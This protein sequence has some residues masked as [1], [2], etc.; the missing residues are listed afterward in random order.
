M[1]ITYP[2]MLV[3]NG[4]QHN[5]LCY[6]V[7][8]KEFNLSDMIVVDKHFSAIVIQNNVVIDTL[9]SDKQ[10]EFKI[11]SLKKL[12]AG[13]FAKTTQLTIIFIRNNINNMKVTQTPHAVMAGGVKCWLGYE[14][15]VTMKLT[16]PEKMWN[17]ITSSKGINPN[18]IATEN[19]VYLYKTTLEEMLTKHF[20]TFVA[21]PMGTTYY[22]QTKYKAA[23]AVSDKMW[24]TY[25]LFG[26]DI[27]AGWTY[28]F[29]KLGKF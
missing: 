25:K 7:P 28:Q 10:K 13:W 3:D 4:L 17:F 9:M 29:T 6:Q 27:Q 16:K 2:R 22:E 1:N 12:K 24:E 18:T 21:T 11:K 5:L 15:I 8:E 20:S 26:Y 19:F 14:F 23:K